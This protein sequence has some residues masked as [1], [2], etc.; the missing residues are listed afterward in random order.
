MKTNR[1]LLVIIVLLL[2]AILGVLVYQANQPEETTGRK[3]EDA[4]SSAGKDIGNA[5]E[6]LGKDIQEQAR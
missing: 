5:I 6:D 3:I 1:A 4:F 2:G